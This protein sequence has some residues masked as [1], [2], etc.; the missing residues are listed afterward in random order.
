MQPDFQT[1]WKPQACSSTQTNHTLKGD[2]MLFILPEA[3]NYRSEISDDVTTK[4]VCRGKLSVGE[5]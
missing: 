1:I 3:T 2:W 5:K 4:I